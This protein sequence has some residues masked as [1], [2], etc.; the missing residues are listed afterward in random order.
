MS[1]LRSIGFALLPAFYAGLAAAQGP[2]VRASVDQTTVVVREPFTFRIE[3]T[4]GL[5]D[6]IVFPPRVDVDGLVM[7]QSARGSQFSIVG[8][9]GTK[10][11]SIE[12]QM[13]ATRTGT[14]TIPPY[15]V[16]IG[17]RA[18]Q[19]EPVTVVVVDRGQAGDDLKLTMDDLLFTKAFVDKQEVYQG[20]PVL[21]TL[22]VWRI[23]YRG[24]T[25]QRFRG[26]DIRYPSTE[27]FY[28]ADLEPRNRYDARGPW[29][30]EVAEERK[31]LYPTATGDLRIGSWHWEG[32]ATIPSSRTIL[33]REEFMYRLDSD[34][35][36]VKV[37]PLPPRP[38]GFSGA[39][40]KFKLVAHVKNDVVLQGVPEKILTVTIDGEGNPDAIGDP[41]LPPLPW[42]YVSEPERSTSL[43]VDQDT[44]RLMVEKRFAYPI[45]PLEAGN[46]VIP[47]ISFLYFDPR[48]ERYKNEKAGPFRLEVKQSL[49]ADHKLVISPHLDA[50]ERAVDILGQDIRPL[51][52]RPPR[53]SVKPDSTPWVPVLGL[54]PVVG[55]GALAAYAARKRRFKH[56]RGFA[57]AYRAKARALKRLH[58]SIFSKEPADDL[59]RA[60]T[61]FIGDLYNVD[62]SGMTSSD[63]ADIL[64]ERGIDGPLRETLVKIVRSCE[65]VRYGSHT[66]S[67]AEL[68]ALVEGAESCI[69]Q[70][71]ALRSGGKR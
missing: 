39:V 4:G 38:A 35:I 59:Y 61:G 8:V 11:E 54:L 3:A 49:E 55:Y 45:T 37:K 40:G 2:S 6:P 23:V 71:D 20:E 69:H 58:G 66:I 1:P 10:T 47:E 18:F 63:V 7:N 28:V 27:G 57:R 24:I 52:A 41:A 5:N 42:A 16:H 17:A 70:L 50:Q 33:G 21:L 53:L 68:R 30:Y 44:Q 48:E 36:D 34:P 29:Q 65:R 60:V 67:E 64:K 14:F 31:L 46:V 51:I 62:N 26:A 32:V 25:T 9:S 56:D 43:R 22:E 13:Y 19:T 12:F 15:Q